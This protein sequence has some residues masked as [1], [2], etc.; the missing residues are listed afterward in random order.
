MKLRCLGSGSSGNCYLLS[1]SGGETLI[2]EA[3]VNFN[4]VEKAL[5]F[6]IRGVVGCL[7]THRHRDHSEY[8]PKFLRYG[9]RVFALMD[10]FN[11]FVGSLP[12]AFCFG[13]EA[14]RGYKV[15]DFKFF[16]VAANHDAP[17]LGF[18]IEHEEMGR[19]LFL[20]D[21]MTADFNV[22]GLNHIMIEANYS[23]ADLNY[24]ID[25]GITAASMRGRLYET[26]MNL[27]TTIEA[28]KRNAA[29]ANEVI[30]IHLSGNNSNA[31]EFIQAAEKAIG[32]P[33]YAAKKGFECD[34]SLKPY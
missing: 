28:L 15:M 22:K 1:A 26:H 25:N 6:N 3:G 20:T 21:T 33:V 17:C 8:L 2:I 18:V 7:V 16:A 4:E 13:I 19:L 14:G 12:K 5:G 23:D 27:N 24:N 31:D 11:S 29:Q 32:K 9:I 34:L 30:L 10:V